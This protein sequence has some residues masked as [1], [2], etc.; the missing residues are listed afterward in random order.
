MY[1]MAANE[2]TMS[3]IMSC[4]TPLAIQCQN[5]INF[6]T[7]ALMIGYIYSHVYSC[8]HGSAMGCCIPYYGPSSFFIYIMLLANSLTRPAKCKLLVSQVY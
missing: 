4:G 8:M 6:M 2:P 5:N 3:Y 7:V 1:R